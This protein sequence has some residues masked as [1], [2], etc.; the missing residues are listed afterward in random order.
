LDEKKRIAEMTTY[1]ISGFCTGLRGEGMLLIELAGM[2][3]SLV[4]MDDVKNAHFI[5]VVSGHTKDNQLSGAKFGL[6]CAPVTEE[7]HLRPGCLVKC[8]EKDIHGSRRVGGSL[9][10]RIHS[11]NYTT[12]LVVPL[13]PR[14]SSRTMDTMNTMDTCQEGS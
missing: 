5:F 11:P 7:A 8:F 13:N 3:Y 14:Y 2:A 6:P 1:F 9:F 4:H 12:I 10:S